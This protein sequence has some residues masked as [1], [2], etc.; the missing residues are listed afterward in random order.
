MKHARRARYVLIA[1]LLLLA[2]NFPVLSAANKRLF[3]G[4][5]P[6]LYI[7]LGAVWLLFILVVFLTVTGKASNDE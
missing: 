4:G 6:L 7:Y 1:I 5:F 2:T 3:I